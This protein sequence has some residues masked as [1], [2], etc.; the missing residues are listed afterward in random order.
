MG[1]DAVVATF[2]GA[3]VFKDHVAAV[4]MD[5]KAVVVGMR[6]RETVAYI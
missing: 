4:T 6:G 1:A 2:D 5:V 3:D